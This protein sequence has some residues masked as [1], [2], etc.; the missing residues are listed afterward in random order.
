MFAEWTLSRSRY[1][2]IIEN[3]TL[4]DH[5]W[6]SHGTSREFYKGILDDQSRGVF[7]GLIIVE[8]LDAQKSDSTQTS[9]NLL[10]STEALA[11]ANPES[12]K[13][14]ANDVK[15]KHGGA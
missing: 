10:L 5:L 7:D 4:I 2:E 15:C 9:R 8:K 3:H 11:Q 14:F 6:K 13:I 1:K 12:R